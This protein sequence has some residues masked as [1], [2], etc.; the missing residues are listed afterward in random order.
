MISC[1]G[2]RKNKAYELW[3]TSPSPE[4]VKSLLDKEAQ[5]RNRVGQLVTRLSRAEDEEIP[6]LSNDIVQSIAELDKSLAAI[7]HAIE[8]GFGKPLPPTACAIVEAI[9]RLLCFRAKQGAGQLKEDGM[10][11]P[12]G[13]DAIHINFFAQLIARTYLRQFRLTTTD[14]EMRIRLRDPSHW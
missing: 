1:K 4:R 12:R 14:I 10:L 9:K 11:F 6:Q 8:W 5:C 7:V 13:R 3:P 2:R